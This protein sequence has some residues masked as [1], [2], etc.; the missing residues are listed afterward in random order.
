MFLLVL[1]V[2][3]PDNCKFQPTIVI[4]ILVWQLRQYIKYWLAIFVHVSNRTF[5]SLYILLAYFSIWA[6]SARMLL[7]PKTGTL[8][9]PS[10]L[11]QTAAHIRQ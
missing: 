6:L 2:V 3:I 1:F 7:I 9:L 5:D 11:I 4:I 10:R 8:E